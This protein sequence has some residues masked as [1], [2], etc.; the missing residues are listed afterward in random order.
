MNKW[1]TPLS[2]GLIFSIRQSCTPFLQGKRNKEIPNVLLER[3]LKNQDFET[4]SSLLQKSQDL[5]TL[6]NTS[7]RQNATPKRRSTQRLKTVSNDFKPIILICINCTGRK[8]PQIISERE[9]TITSE[10]IYGKKILK[11]SSRLWETM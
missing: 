1:T 8:D 11:R 5:P 9:D 6:H 3:G 4:K 7:V 10:A 2:K